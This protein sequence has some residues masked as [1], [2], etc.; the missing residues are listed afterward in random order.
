[1]TNGKALFKDSKV[2]SDFD[3]TELAKNY[4]KIDY[5]KPDGK[6]SFD[7]LTSVSRS[8]TNHDHD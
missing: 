1:M 8:S 4:T 6:V 3:A 5:P 2:E 7:L